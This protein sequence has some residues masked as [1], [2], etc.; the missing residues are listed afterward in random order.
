MHVKIQWLK[1]VKYSDKSKL[2]FI[3]Y[4]RDTALIL[5]CKNNLLDVALEMLKYK[6]EF[7]YKHMNKEHNT[8]LSYARKNNMDKVIEIIENS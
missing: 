8:A 6:K 7:N 1:G 3:N 4:D 2:G 5:A